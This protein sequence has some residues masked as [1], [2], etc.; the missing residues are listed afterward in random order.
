MTT[1][2]F[3]GTVI[4]GPLSFFTS[5][6]VEEIHGKT[7]KPIIRYKNTFFIIKI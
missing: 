7:I 5:F 3:P 1:F 2:P 6:I 4:I